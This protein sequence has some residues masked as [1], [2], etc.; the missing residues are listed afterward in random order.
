MEKT[1][2]PCPSHFSPQRLSP[3]LHPTKS[4]PFLAQILQRDAEV[5]Y[6]VVDAE[7]AVMGCL[8]S[9]WE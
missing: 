1:F 3:N 6:R 2:Y 9:C 8:V 5:I 4:E 7:E